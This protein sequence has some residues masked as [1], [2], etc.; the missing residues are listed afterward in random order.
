MKKI[1][2]I[3]LTLVTIPL[4]I[5]LTILIRYL[6][7]A[8]FGIAMHPAFSLVIYIILFA[9]L[10]VVAEKMVNMDKLPWL[11]SDNNH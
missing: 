3:K 5:V 7:S 9:S 6:I 11:L 4:A 1:N 10:K 2:P 8:V